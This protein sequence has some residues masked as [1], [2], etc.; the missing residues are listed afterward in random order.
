[1]AKKRRQEA[2][3]E[4]EAEK[5]E[6][7]TEEDEVHPG[8]DGDGDGD[9]DEDTFTPIGD[10]ILDIVFRREVSQQAAIARALVA[11]DH[12]EVST[13]FGGSAHADTA[14]QEGEQVGCR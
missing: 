7:E 12:R 9:D 11:G 1:M 8:G 13:P 4:A 6:I 3:P 2:K 5:V 14:Q 10:Q